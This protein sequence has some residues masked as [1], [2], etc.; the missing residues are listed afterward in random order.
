MANKRELLK[1]SKHDKTGK[2]GDRTYGEALFGAG[3]DASGSPLA[4]AEAY[5]AGKMGLLDKKKKRQ[6]F[7]NIDGMKIAIRKDHR[8]KKPKYKD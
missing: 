5:V 3:P 8:G 7:T 4:A 2:L 6:E 1:L